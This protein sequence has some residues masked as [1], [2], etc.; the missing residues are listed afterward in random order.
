MGYWQCR[1][2]KRSI[3]T[4]E[5][6][7]WV[8][9]GFFECSK[10]RKT[11]TKIYGV[12]KLRLSPRAKDLLRISGG[13][14]TDNDTVFSKGTYKSLESRKLL[15]VLY[16]IPSVKPGT[17]KPVYRITTAGKNVLEIMRHMR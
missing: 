10:D 2:C 9:G 15:E 4:T 13:F 6:I 12:H 1:K 16:R 5:P 11:C 17:D 3:P 8:R 14:D 7:R